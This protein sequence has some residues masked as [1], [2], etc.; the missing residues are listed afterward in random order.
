MNIGL[1]KMQEVIDATVLHRFL[2]TIKQFRFF[3]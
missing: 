3:K 1:E 2:I